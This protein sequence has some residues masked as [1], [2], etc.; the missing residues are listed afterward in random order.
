MDDDDFRRGL[1][2]NHKK[3]G[4]ALA[5]LAGDSLFVLPVEA[6]LEADGRFDVVG[7][8]SNGAEAVGLASSRRPD[9]VT[10]DIAMP[11]LDGVEA[12]RAICDAFPRM[13]VV[14]LTG[15]EGGDHVGDALAAGAVAHVTK[16]HA[17]EELPNVLVAAVEGR[18]P[19]PR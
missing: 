10:M 17:A 5:L 12:T 18:L 9:V 7:W 15:S 2:S 6:L 19:Q 1:P 14:V 13:H 11:I 16:R 3:F 8:A 4:E